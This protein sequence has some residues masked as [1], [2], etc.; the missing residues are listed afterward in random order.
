MLP[1]EKF[2]E[3]AEA[4]LKG[5][6]SKAECCSTFG[7]GKLRGGSQGVRGE[8]T[9]MTIVYKRKEAKLVIDYETTGL[10]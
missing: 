4:Q 6:L 3:T 10:P 1:A 5:T 9:A 7:I 8:V 2:Q